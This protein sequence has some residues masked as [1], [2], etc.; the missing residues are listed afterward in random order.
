MTK[1]EIMTKDNFIFG[2]SSTRQ[3]S[4]KEIREVVREGL[5]GIDRKAAQKFLNGKPY[6]Y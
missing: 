2:Y 4:D 6:E 1:I 5:Q 3:L